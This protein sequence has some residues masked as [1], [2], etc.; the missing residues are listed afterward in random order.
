MVKPISSMAN[1]FTKIASSKQGQQLY[2]KILNP[3]YDSFW[4]QTMPIVETSVATVAYILNTNAQ[5]NIDKKSKKAIQI[6]NILSWVVSLGISIPLNK[7]L[8]KF[9]KSVE[10]GLNPALVKDFHK[11]SQGLNIIAPLVSVTL[12]NRAILPSVLVPVSSVIRDKYESKKKNK[13]INLKA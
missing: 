8:D 5:K 12:L 10:R 7:Q 13:P 3:K 9:T 11:V 4:N 1:A 6:Q 2:N